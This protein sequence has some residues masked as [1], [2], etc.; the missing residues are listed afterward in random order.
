MVYAKRDREPA[1]ELIAVLSTRLRAA[2]HHW[3]LL[4]YSDVPV[5]KLIEKTKSRQQRSA[6]LTL[7]LLSPELISDL[8]SDP[9]FRTD[10]PLVPLALRHIEDAHLKDTILADRSVFRDSEDKVWVQCRGSGKDDWADQALTGILQ[11]IRLTNPD[12]YRVLT[13]P[14]LCQPD[15]C[16]PEHY[17]GQI[18][19]GYANSE[20]R[21]ALGLLNDWLKDPEGSVFCAIFGELGMGKITLCQRLTRDLLA[22]RAQDPELPLP[23]YLD[24][25]EVN[26]LDWDWSRGV[27]ELER[28]LHHILATAYNLP[29]D[30]PRPG[31]EDIRR[32]TQQGGSS[33]STAWTRS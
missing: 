4:D 12:P 32:L 25:R 6:D 17:A 18:L 28:M 30:S 5:G 22:R 33:S 19:K 31:V 16:R 9:D 8:R 13:N 2:G 23:V 21:E 26:S 15:D 14:W 29:V 11:C 1:Q 10:R 7:F 27:P 3:D 20:G 24:L